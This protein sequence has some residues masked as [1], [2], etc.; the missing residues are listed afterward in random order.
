MPGLRVGQEGELVGISDPTR[1]SAPAN[2]A[3]ETRVP[4]CCQEEP[5]YAQLKGPPFA[6]KGHDGACTSPLLPNSVVAPWMSSRSTLVMK[7]G[8]GRKHGC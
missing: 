1:T 4:T 6:E 5:T 8:A 7:G 2:P 3:V